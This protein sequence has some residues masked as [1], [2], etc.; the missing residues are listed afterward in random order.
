M[1]L[2]IWW[3]WREQWNVMTKNLAS[4]FSSIAEPQLADLQVKTVAPV[5]TLIN[6][7]GDDLSV[8]FGND[9]NHN[10]WYLESLSPNLASFLTSRLPADIT[11][12]GNKWSKKTS[13][14]KINGNGNMNEKILMTIWTKNLDGNMNEKS[15]RQYESNN[16]FFQVLSLTL[17]ASFHITT[18]LPSRW[19]VHD[20]RAFGNVEDI[21]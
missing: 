15:W 5:Y 7:Y 19:T 12:W 3:W 18:N 16:W 8:W 21:T 20:N 11:W 13:N 1:M 2:M 14:R 10:W 4:I 9:D 6:T 17:V